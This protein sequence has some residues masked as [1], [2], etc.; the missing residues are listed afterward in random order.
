MSTKTVKKITEPE[1]IG[2]IERSGY[3]IEQRVA[4]VVREHGYLVQASPAYTD[5]DT[6]KSREYDISG[7]KVSMLDRVTMD[8]VWTVLVCECENNEQPVVFFTSESLLAFMSMKYSGLPVKI[9]SGKK[10]VPLWEFLGAKRFHHYGKGSVATQYCTFHHKSETAPWV[11]SHSE[12]HQTFMSL[13]NAV[14]HGID[15]HCDNWVPPGRQ[16]ERINIQMFYPVLILQGD[17]YE[18]RTEKPPTEIKAVTN[19]QYCKELWDGRGSKTYYIDVV[20]EKYLPKYLDLISKE[21]EAIRRRLR[22]E[23]K[24]VHKSLDFITEQLLA[25]RRKRNPLPLR[26]F[27]GCG[28][29]ID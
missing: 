20:S 21:I 16:K 17:I 3:P 26:T 2:A 28:G 27:L 6:G 14:E 23:R 5:P 22:R 1:M 13:I 10:L 9:I 29:I 11:A 25:N 18:I 7:I 4:K 24:I 8:S 15:D 12:A 19:V